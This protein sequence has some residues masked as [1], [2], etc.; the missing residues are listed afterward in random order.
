[1][2]RR[3]NVAARGLRVNLGCGSEP[4]A[5]FLNIDRLGAG[6]DARMDAAHLALRDGSVERLE[7]LHLVEHLGYLGAIHALCEWRRVMRPGARLV[8]ETPDFPEAARRFVAADF[9][10]RALLANWIFGL[11]SPGMT[12][13]FGFEASLLARTLARCGFR[14]VREEPARAHRGF[15]GLRLFAVRGDSRADDVHAAFVRLVFDR[16]LPGGDQAVAVEI[17]HGLAPTVR[18]AFAR[19]IHRIEAFD[20]MFARLAAADPAL[21]RAALDAAGGELPAPARREWTAL[22]SDPAVAAL[23]RSLTAELLRRPPRPGR[24]EAAFRSLAR[25]ARGWL[26]AQ[27]LAVRSGRRLHGFPRPATE[28]RAARWR[29]LASPVPAPSF[30]GSTT[31]AATKEI[32]AP[33]LPAGLAR[34]ARNASA[35]GRRLFAAGDLEDAA[36]ALTRAA[37]LDADSPL[38]HWNLARLEAANGRAPAALARYDDALAAAGRRRVPCRAHLRREREAVAAGRRVPAAPVGF[39][40]IDSGEETA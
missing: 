40:E 13:R 15:P 16:D 1:M 27:L 37:A 21:A 14:R 25:R 38:P 20:A 9:E 2:L 4:R 19:R 10:G 7:A 36:E 18:R 12:H 28:S 24:Q 22:L 30:H 39:L 35:R 11:E 26:A 32:V 3:R 34:A 33:F 6:A 31:E 5:G 17:V 29:G 8:L 23:P